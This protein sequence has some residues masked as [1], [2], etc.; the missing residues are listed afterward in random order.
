MSSISVVIITYNE[1]RNIERCIE[2]AMKVSDDIV[3]WDS[4]SDD[5]TAFICSQYPVRFFQAAWEG[6]SISKNKANEQAK[7][8]WILSLDADEALSELLIQSILQMVSEGLQPAAFARLTNYCGSWIHHCGWYPDAKWR[9]FNRKAV[10]WE[11]VIHESLQ[12]MN[13]EKVEIKFLQGD[14]LHYS[15]YTKE[16]HYKQAEKFVTI[17]AREKVEAGKTTFWW[18]RWLSPMSKFFQMYFVKGGI[19]D[20]MAGWKVCIRSSWAAYKKY[21]LWYDFQQHRN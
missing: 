5:R 8:D 19:L 14:C 12:S 3:I 20:G 9:I 2:S 6:Y 4:F 17:M 10:Q 21:Q 13:N 7:H 15:Y 16:D 1:E 18:M 11:G